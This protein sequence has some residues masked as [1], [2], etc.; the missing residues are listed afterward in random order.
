MNDIHIN[1]AIE[2]T[3]R[4]PADQRAA[5]AA[6]LIESLDDEADSDA[7]AFLGRGN[8]TAAG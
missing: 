3:M 1:D 2:S 8:T 4:L 6:L 7:E 5:L